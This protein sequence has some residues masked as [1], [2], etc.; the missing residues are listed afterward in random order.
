M[1][2]T[3]AFIS[4][5]MARQPN[6]E[7]KQFFSI[8]WLSYHINGAIRTGMKI[9]TARANIVIVIINLFHNLM[10]LWFCYYLNKTSFDIRSLSPL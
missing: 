4:I 6:N 3:S 7:S 8:I 9:I 1:F 5:L 10:S 2:I